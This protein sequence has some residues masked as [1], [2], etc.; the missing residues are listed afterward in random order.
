MKH[1]TSALLFLRTRIINLNNTTMKRYALFMALLACAAAYGQGEF[2]IH[3]NGLI[4]D[5]ATM[6]RLG[7]IVDSLNVKFRTCD[8]SRPHHSL[9]QGRGTFVAV[10]NKE[11]R[12]L[13]ANNISLHDY[14]QRYPKSA[15]HEN[16]YITQSRYTGYKDQRLIEYSGLPYGW[17]NEPTVTVPDKPRNDKTTGWVVDEEGDEALYI[18]SLT[19]TALPHS[20]A[21]LVQYV[22]CM[23]D[24]TASI[25]FPSAEGKIYQ[26]VAAGTKA[27]EF[28]AW[29]DSYPGQPTDPNYDAI[30]EQ[31]K[32]WDSVL[33]IYWSEYRAW[34]SIRMAYLDHQVPN[35]HYWRSVLMEAVDEA[36]EKGNSDARVERYVARYLS[37]T[38]ALKMK[39]SRKVVGGCSMDQS[40]RYHAMDICQLAAETAQWDI[41]L[42]SHL[43]IMNDRFE[44]VSDGSYAWAGRKTYL[45]E[46]EALDIAAIDL[47]LGTSLRVENASD[48]HY[49]GSISRVGRALADTEDKPALEKRLQNMMLDPQ[50]DLYNRLLMAYLFSNYAHNLDETQRNASLA[51]LEN[52]VKQMPKDVQDVWGKER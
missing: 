15:T 39:R 34:D 49:W 19:S 48:K 46:L 27:Q 12:K 3:A 13:I 25:Y 18:E 5:E 32:E 45:K 42:R 37:K 30:M 21:R 31:G 6:N 47:L 7:V 4:Y 33:N 38:D 28:L 35:S 24:T 41:F 16:L 10:R 23:V 14:L 17:N 51:L 29:A 9:A 8:L 20:Y 2:Q 26:Q 11:A 52:T 36:V 40:P 50:L 22:D 43:D 1:P 44:R